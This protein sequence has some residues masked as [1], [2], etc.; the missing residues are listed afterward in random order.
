MQ[1]PAFEEWYLNEYTDDDD[2][3][4]ELAEEDYEG[5]E[6]FYVQ[7]GTEIN[8]EGIEEIHDRWEHMDLFGFGGFDRG[9]NKQ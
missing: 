3:D 4:D 9:G 5:L 1:H 8:F 6:Q 2:D 7:Q